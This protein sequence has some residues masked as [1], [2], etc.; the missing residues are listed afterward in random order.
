MDWKV[1]A[2]LGGC[3]TAQVAQCWSLTRLH[4]TRFH[5]FRHYDFVLKLNDDSVLKLN[6]DPVLKLSVPWF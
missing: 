6:E 1:V 4:F 5:S 2:Q 3:A